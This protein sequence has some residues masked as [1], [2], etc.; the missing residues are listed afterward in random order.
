MQKVI[1][2][3]T[4]KIAHLSNLIRVFPKVVAAKLVAKKFLVL[5][6][7]FPGGYQAIFSI[8]LLASNKPQLFPLRCC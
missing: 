7:N 8:L 2:L 1:L 6:I 3:G 4:H 5:L